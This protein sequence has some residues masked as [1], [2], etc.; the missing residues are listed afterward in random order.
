MKNS[1]LRSSV[2]ARCTTALWLACCA[3]RVLAG[4][5]ISPETHFTP[6]TEP[7]L[8]QPIA[9][10]RLSE[11]GFSSAHRIR[12]QGAEVPHVHDRHDLTV[13][14]RTGVARIHLRQGSIEL[15][16]GDSLYIPAGTPHWAEN[17]GE[18]ASEALVVFAPAFDG[19]DRR[20]IDWPPSD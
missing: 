7:Q 10:Q 17:A 1:I 13:T 11:G 3:S 14:I 6:W 18:G 2:L 8:A 12:M 20:P 19:K 4:E 5:V 15:K 16:P 9:V